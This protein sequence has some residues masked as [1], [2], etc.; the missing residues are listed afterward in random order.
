MKNSAS[1]SFMVPEGDSLSWSFTKTLWLYAVLLPTLFFGYQALSIPLVVGSVCLLFAAV[2]IGHSI[3]LHRGIIHRTYECSPF[4]RKLLTYL[5]VHSG[6]GG[7]ISW[8]KLHY[9]RDYWQ[10]KPDCPRY[11]QYSH[12]MW[13]DYFWNLH[14][15]YDTPNWG[16]YNLP[17]DAL[18]DPWLIWL[19][20]TWVWHNLT[21]AALVGMLLGFNAV[22]I[23]F[24]ARV[25]ASILGHWIVGFL[26]HKFGY[27]RYKIQSAKESAYNDWFWGVVS[28]GEGFHNNHHAHPS[29]AKM[30]QFWYEV[31]IGWWV[32]A[33][34]E[35]IG[36]VWN[37]KTFERIRTD[38][39]GVVIDEKGWKYPWS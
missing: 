26:T 27:T 5:F 38:R 4:T 31:D 15:S 13:L 10:N 34:M 30:G 25:S 29:S 36:L 14:L 37:V 35:A 23:L 22:I 18:A 6:L 20:E 1:D 2:C 28:F 33:A 32:I 39:P 24:C 11:F 3:G 12:A 21:F 9:V 16:R 8:I 17:K 7:P 19:E